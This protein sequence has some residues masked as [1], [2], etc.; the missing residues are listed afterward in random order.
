MEVGAKKTEVPVTIEWKGVRMVRNHSIR[1]SVRE[2][3]TMA[4]S[5]DVVKINIVGNPGT[6]K[7]TL[8]MTLGHLIHKISEEL[9]HV[10]FAVRVFD[11]EDL[12]NFEQT[13]RN[14]QPVNHVLIFD[15]VSFL[16]AK[17]DKKQI[18]IIKQ[19][20]TEIRHLP[21]GQD[22]KI[23]AIFN[24]HYS[25]SFDKYLRQCNF[26]YYTTVG[27]SELENMQRI[28][29]IKYTP[30]LTKF[31]EMVNIALTTE[32]FT[33][34]L[35]KKGKKFTYSYRKPFI[36]V[37][38]HNGHTLRFVVSPKR[39]F[40]D[41]ICSVCVQAR[42]V[43]MKDGLSVENFAKDLSYKFGVQIARNAVRIKL[44]QNGINVYPRQVKRAM[45]YIER[46]MENKIINLQELAG[47]YDFYA[48]QK[49][50]HA[51]WPKDEI[52]NN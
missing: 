6:G 13:L 19:N 47:Y 36:P 4:Q 45:E 16:G 33:F 52:S 39:E 37:L 46:Y 14:L 7:T 41:P 1:A 28:V 38:F 24:F 29:G 10:P 30:H 34:K 31:Q 9:Y 42:Q 27:S 22:V 15:D 23:V 32:Q 26:S 48:D 40:I 21:G 43:P 50:I 12:L 17:A 20:F 35:G 51:P 44:F 3:V 11:K 8:A 18:E 2:I 25:L 49:R 5:L